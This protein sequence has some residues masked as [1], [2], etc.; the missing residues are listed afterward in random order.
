[1]L[2]PAPFTISRSISLAN[3]CQPWTCALGH[4]QNWMQFS[5]IDRCMQ[6]YVCSVHVVHEIARVPLYDLEMFRMIRVPMWAAPLLIAIQCEDIS[7]KHC[8]MSETCIIFLRT[9]HGLW[10]CVS[11]F[12]NQFFFARI[13]FWP[14]YAKRNAVCSC[15]RCTCKR[16]HPH[17]TFHITPNARNILIALWIFAFAEKTA[18]HNCRSINTI[19]DMHF[20][21]DIA[22]ICMHMKLQL[23]EF[24]DYWRN[25]YN[26]NIRDTLKT[27]NVS[28]SMCIRRKHIIDQPLAM[29]PNDW[30]SSESN[31][32]PAAK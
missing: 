21:F 31:N 5:R 2:A 18:A 12:V 26:L 30:G 17:S 23:Y 4:K 1:M 22:Y 28:E 7:I 27:I 3:L 20:E 14:R 24:L 32:L 8:E 9:K 15:T 10:L 25:A 11:L 6:C 13:S 29:L 16:I 19:S